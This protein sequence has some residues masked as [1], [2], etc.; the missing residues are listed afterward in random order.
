M[1]DFFVFT[2]I[3]SP[4][5]RLPETLLTISTSEVKIT[6]PESFEVGNLKKKGGTLTFISNIT[7]ILKYTHQMFSK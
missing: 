7:E 6:T 5:L 4:I 3:L 1:S 2:E